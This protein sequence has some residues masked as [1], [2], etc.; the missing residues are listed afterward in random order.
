MN[1]FRMNFNFKGYH[2][3]NLHRDNIKSL[4]EQDADRSFSISNFTESLANK[5][6]ENNA[7][8]ETQKENIEQTYQEASDYL[9]L[10]YR[11]KELSKNQFWERLSR[12]RKELLNNKTYFQTYE[13]LAYG[14]KV[15][16]RNNGRC[17]ARLFWK[18]LIVR[19]LR[20]LSTAEEIFN[21]CVEHIRLATN[22]GKIRSVISIFAPQTPENSGIRIINPFMIRYAGYRQSNGEVIGDAGS[23]EFTEF[24]QSLGWKKENKTHFDL[25][26]LVIQMPGEEPQIFD[27]PPDAIM[28]VPIEH[29]EY[30]WFSEFG[31]KWYVLPIVS[32][33]IL[34]IGGISYTA[35]P[36]S[37]WYMSSEIA[38]RNF[39]DT[40]RY[41]M[42]PKVAEK[43]GLNTKSHVSLWKDR[44]LIELN[45]A[46]LHSFNLKGVTIV[47]HHTAS[48]Q[49]MA[50]I[51][52]E[53]EK[54]RKVLADW[55]W[56]VPPLSG[57][58]TEVFHREFEN[59]WIKPNF[60][61]RNLSI[62][63]H[64]HVGGCPFHS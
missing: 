10:L 39:A 11:E 2:K 23:V 60:F 31:L 40:D 47:D 13:E 41:N 53:K 17:I 15:A 37:G 63:S 19:D 32:E 16:W 64:K 35:A 49:F 4:P 9:K 52:K 25:L 21:A 44:A 6:M 12:V 8:L 24:V 48:R 46:V 7:G 22:Q 18:E 58:T 61:D 59:I 27:L 56:I 14:C 20:H 5:Q 62:N 50:H 54:G 1:L 34:S 36:F 55:G 42:L 51:E 28:E 38:S 30:D 26:P 45:T 29:P 3:D 33:K 43:M 57:S